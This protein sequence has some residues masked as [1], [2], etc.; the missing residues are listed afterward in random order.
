M[1]YAIDQTM[2]IKREEN[3]NALNPQVYAYGDSPHALFK[4]TRFQVYLAVYGMLPN[5]A[6]KS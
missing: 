6:N 1:V 4:Q 3:C 2:F 5:Q